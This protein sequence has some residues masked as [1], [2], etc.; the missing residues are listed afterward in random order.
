MC[1]TVYSTG[2]SLWNILDCAV[3]TAPKG[4]VR[5]E[6][7]VGLDITNY[8]NIEIIIIIVLKHNNSIE[9]DIIL[10][11]KLLKLSIGARH[12]IINKYIIN[13]IT[14]SKIYEFGQKANI[15]YIIFINGDSHVNI[16]CFVST[17]SDKLFNGLFKLSA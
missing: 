3:Y 6:I 8:L 13:N 17:T 12:E 9:T 10:L 15:T 14:L 7:C 5:D 16:F 2:N 4:Y 1:S 11:M